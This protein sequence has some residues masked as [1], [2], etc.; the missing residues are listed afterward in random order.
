MIRKYESSPRRKACVFCGDTEE[1]AT[2]FKGKW[3]CEKCLKEWREFDFIFDKRYK[4]IE[5]ICG[6]INKAIDKAII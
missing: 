2:G 5:K 3:V 1:S 6:K 4:E